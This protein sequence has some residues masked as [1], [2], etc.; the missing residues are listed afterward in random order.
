MYNHDIKTI[1]SPCLRHIGANKTS[2][3]LKSSES[4]FKYDAINN[5]S[6]RRRYYFQH[7]NFPCQSFILRNITVLTRFSN[8]GYL[9]SAEFT[10]K[11][12]GK[13]AVYTSLNGI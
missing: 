2:F 4:C 12:R 8:I 6:R 13:C 7:Y 9:K 11:D 10:E 1:F 3:N 5:Y